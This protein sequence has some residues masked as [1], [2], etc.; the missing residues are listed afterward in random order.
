MCGSKAKRQLIL[1]IEN[2]EVLALV[3]F[4]FRALLLL[5]P[6]GW[7]TMLQ[8]ARLMSFSQDGLDTV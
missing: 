2:G 5:I 3:S 8:H 6:W 1:I 7:H 4:L